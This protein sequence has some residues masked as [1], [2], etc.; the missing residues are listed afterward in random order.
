[1]EKTLSILTEWIT[2]PDPG[3]S[4][5]TWNA[6]SSL[7]TRTMAYGDPTRSM[8]LIRRLIRDMTDWRDH[9]Y[10]ESLLAVSQAVSARAVL[11]LKD[12]LEG[13]DTGE[14]LFMMDG[15]LVHEEELRELVVSSDLGIR[16]SLRECLQKAAEIVKEEKHD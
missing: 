12:W 3:F 11:T 6:I 5:G 2:K 1:M 16:G 8:S 7:V 13:R 10:A 4:R 9:T 15:G 14:L